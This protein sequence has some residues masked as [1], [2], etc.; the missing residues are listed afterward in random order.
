MS[1]IVRIFLIILLVLVVIAGAIFG[2]AYFF[3]QVPEL[4]IKE[5]SSQA[6]KIEAIDQW[7]AKLEDKGKFNGS[8]LIAKDGAPLLL[9]A[10]GYTDHKK[11][12]RLTAQ[13]AF[14]LAS[15]SKQFTATGI[16]LLHEAGQLNYDTAVSVYLENYPYEGVTVRHLLNHT[17]GMP[18]LYM[19]LA[20]THKATLGDTL[21]IDEVVQLMIRYPEDPVAAPGAVYAYNNTGYVLLAAIVQS[22]SGQSFEQF[23]QDKL[24]DPLEMKNTRVWNL[25][26]EQSTFPNKTASFINMVKAGPMPPSWLDGVAGDGAVF[27]SPEDFLIWDQFWYGNDLISQ[28]NLKEAFK[29]PKLA[30]GRISDYGFGWT[31]PNE[32]MVWH[33]GAWLGARTAI[34]RR[35]ENKTC[36]VLLDNSL[37]ERLDDILQQ[38]NLV[39]KTFE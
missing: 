15:V 32:Q 28:E 31:V 33:N 8:I 27:S 30:D 13:S 3:M 22:I 4:E 17:S 11:E 34:I 18:D 26:S 21:S 20:E 37:N 1:S 2:W 39:V 6:E 9:N 23:M 25:F 10:Y 19:D 38:I 5:S 14:R 35:M 24:F 29:T 7:L 36:L 12:T 16:M